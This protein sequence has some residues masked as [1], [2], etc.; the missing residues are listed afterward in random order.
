MEERNIGICKPAYTGHLVAR[1]ISLAVQRTWRTNRFRSSEIWLVGAALY[2]YERV[3]MG[4]FLG[5]FGAM[6]QLCVLLVLFVPTFYRYYRTVLTSVLLLWWMMTKWTWKYISDV[7]LA[8][9]KKYCYIGGHVT[10]QK[11][12]IKRQSWPCWHEDYCHIILIN[13]CIRSPKVILQY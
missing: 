8:H 2:Q 7:I 11:I 3:Y 4:F 5:G 6:A 1:I 10:S 12:K 13:Y 9:W